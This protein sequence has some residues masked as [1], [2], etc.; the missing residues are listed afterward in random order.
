MKGRGRVKKKS[1][2]VIGLVYILAGLALAATGLMIDSELDSILFGFGV[3]MAG[4]GIGTVVRYLYWTAP[5]NRERY[6]EKIENENIELHDEM[7]VKLRDKAGRYTYG[8]GLLVI[9]ISI[10]VFSILGKLELI[11][12]ERLI[13]LY[14]SGYFIFQI[15]AGMVIFRCLLR[16]YQ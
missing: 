7:K 12:S 6:R 9:C 1:E 14:L 4:G 8:L 15:A 3:G 10:L 13:V 16:K 5:K 2:F 11:H